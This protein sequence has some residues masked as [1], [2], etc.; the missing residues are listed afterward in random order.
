MTAGRSESRGDALAT[1]QR[2]KTVVR[3]TAPPTRHWTCRPS[4]SRKRG[5]WAV[6]IVVVF[7]DGV[8][9]KRIDTRPAGPAP[10]YRPT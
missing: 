2:P 8:V 1:E 9:R 6:E 3:Q 7:A 5:R 4:W 10:N